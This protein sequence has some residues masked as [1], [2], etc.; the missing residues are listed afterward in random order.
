MKTKY[1]KKRLK[2]RIAIMIYKMLLDKDLDDIDS[3]T[4]TINIQTEC[5][6][7]LD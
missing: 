2:M 3:I 4:F 6:L 7:I 5:P 1:E